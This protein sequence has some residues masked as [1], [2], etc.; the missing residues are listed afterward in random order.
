MLR[1]LSC[2]WFV[3]HKML[4][5][6]KLL[7]LP[8]WCKERKDGHDPPEICWTPQVEIPCSKPCCITGLVFMMCKFVI[9]GK[10]G[11]AWTCIPKFGCRSVEYFHCFEVLIHSVLRLEERL[12]NWEE[13]VLDAFHT[14]VL[15][16]TKCF[17]T[18]YFLFAS[19]PLITS[20]NTGVLWYWEIWGGYL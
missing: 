19:K 8:S 3:C 2:H 13:G 6:Q 17:Y 15:Y 16:A 10:F 12:N 5:Q 7:L 4:L 9:T 11:S 18:S 1:C 14:P 20:L